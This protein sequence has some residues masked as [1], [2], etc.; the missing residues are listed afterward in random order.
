MLVWLLCNWQFAFRSSCISYVVNECFFR[1]LL[2]SYGNNG[3]FDNIIIY[4]LRLKL[5]QKN[6]F[7]NKFRL[8][9]LLDF[10]TLISFH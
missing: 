10:V 1:L 8:T 6:I 5:L 2:I 4:K 3:S 7:K 9:L